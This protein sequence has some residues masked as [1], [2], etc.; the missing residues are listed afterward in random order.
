M[1]PGQ[2]QTNLAIFGIKLNI[3]LIPGIFMIIAALI[4]WKF[5]IDGS[6]P[7]YKEWK[8]KIEK[9]HDEKLE[10]LRASCPPD[11]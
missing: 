7:E 10:A 9:I 2:S 6:K 3:G 1:L 5:P 8:K 4:L 11:E